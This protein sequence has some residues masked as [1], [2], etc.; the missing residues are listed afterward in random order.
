VTAPEPS[1]LPPPPSTAV[2]LAAD[3][4]TLLRKGRTKIALA[5]LERLPPLI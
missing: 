4:L 2:E 1:R 3:V 5:Q